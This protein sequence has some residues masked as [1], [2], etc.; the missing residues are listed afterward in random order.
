M[1]L[2]INSTQRNKIFI[3][4]ITVLTIGILIS[5]ILGY[6]QDRKIEANFKKYQYGVQLM[7]A[8]QNQKA[9]EVFN[10]LD[11]DFRDSGEIYYYTAFCY[12]NLKEYPQAV[13]YMKK[14]QDARSPFL[15]DQYFLY[16]FG[17]YLYYIGEV[18]QSRLYLKQSL[19]FAN[20]PELIDKI[21]QLIAKLPMSMED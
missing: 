8:G 7:N 21:N 15:L 5:A 1:N 9:I 18:D 6:N 17:Q 4:L 16:E 19:K 20:D 13:K 10:S 3:V 11:P 2:N 14:A 12:A